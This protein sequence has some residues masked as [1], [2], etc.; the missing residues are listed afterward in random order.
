[1]ANE[2]EIV[3]KPQ[4]GPQSM[5]VGTSADIALGGGAA[6]G[7]KTWSLLFEPILHHLYVPRFGGVIFRRN[8]TQIRNKGGL[9][10]QSRELYGP[11]GAH[12]REATLEWIFSSGITMKFAHLE[13]ENTV[14]DWQGSEIPYLAFDE[15]THF[16]RFQFFYML[17]RNRSTCGVRPYV[18]MTC[19]PDP[20]SF[21]RE[22]VDWWIDEN[23]WP[24]PQRSGVLRWFVVMDDKIE[25]GATKQELIKKFGPSSLPLSFTFIP[26]KLEDNPILMKK[27]PGYP[28]KLN[29]LSKVDRMRLKE[30]NWNIRPTA[31]MYYKRQWFQVIDAIPGGWIRQVRFW[32]RAATQPTPQNPDPDW[33]RGLKLA[34][35]PNGKFVVVNLVSERDTPGKINDLIKNTAS[36]D[37]YGCLQMCQ[38]DP[39]S[40]GK[41]E[42]GNFHKLLA[43]YQT[44]SLPFSQDKET[45]AKASSSAAEAHNIDVVRSDGPKGWNEDFFKETDNFPEGKHDDICFSAGTRIATIF[46]EKPI[47][48]VKM[49][50]MVLT[51]LGL[52]KVLISKCTGEHW[53]ISAHGLIGTPSHPVFQ[54]GVGFIPLDSL[55][56]AF[57]NVLSWKSL[58]RWTCQTMLFSMERPFALW[59]GKNAIT[60]LNQIP[61][62]VESI[63]KDFMSQFMNIFQKQGFLKVS[64]FII[65][66]IIRLIMTSVIWYVYRVGNTTKHL[67]KLIPNS[68]ESI[69][70]KSGHWPRLG[71]DP[72]KEERGIKNTLKTWWLKRKLLFACFVGEVLLPKTKMPNTAPVCVMTGK[73]T[74]MKSGELKENVFIA[75]RCISPNPPRAVTSNPTPVPACAPEGEIIQ[76]V[77]NLEIEGAHCYYANGILVGNCD[78]LSGA[79]NELTN[80]PVVTEAAIKRMG[81]V[82][83]VR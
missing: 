12:P 83:G 24:I 33:T 28:A 73:T 72:K 56:G 34:M 44:K 31:G 64:T 54:E 76:K 35:Y 15:V 11:L 19:N 2:N 55:T 6:G 52:K 27:D 50:D 41:E 58:I 77:Y 40:A 3:L 60:S 47:E 49:G 48:S 74:E 36:Q 17:S 57:N 67:K 63:R 45:R 7:G 5:F 38:Q 16:S 18:R 37:G 26:A 69:W 66:T 10:D 39:G 62:G 65:K 13:Y 20:D 82:L 23:G 4:P 75:E 42:I 21:I 1:M 61:I 68:Q 71:I 80:S 8:T 14:F 25:W 70:R 51:P 30:G 32:D 46:G 79:Y 29:A 78:C 9:W 81:N 22:I 59:A 43:G 53:I